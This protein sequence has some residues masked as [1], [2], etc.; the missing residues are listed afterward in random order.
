MPRLDLLPEDDSH[1]GAAVFLADKGK[2]VSV[3]RA[4]LF[5]GEGAD[6]VEVE[7]EGVRACV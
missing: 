6:I 5:G 4:E 3:E 7:F 1:A 2:D